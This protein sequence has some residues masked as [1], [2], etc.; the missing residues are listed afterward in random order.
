VFDLYGQC[1]GTAVVARENLKIPA[2][3][4]SSSRLPLLAKTTG[5]AL[6]TIRRPGVPGYVILVAR[7]SVGRLQTPNDRI[8]RAVRRIDWTGRSAIREAG[9]PLKERIRLVAVQGKNG[10]VIYFVFV[11]PEVD[12]DVV[13]PIFDRILNSVHVAEYS[14][15]DWLG[16]KT[17]ENFGCPPGIRTPIC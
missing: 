15:F 1:N 14:F 16:G 2:P 12:L 9:Q 8:R 5:H 6:T 17:S 4:T 3:T 13:S 7:I 11:S 10:V